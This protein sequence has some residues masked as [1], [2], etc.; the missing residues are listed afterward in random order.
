M[1]EESST[2]EKGEHQHSASVTITITIS[3]RSHCPF[4]QP[5]QLCFCIVKFYVHF[6]NI[7][8]T[9]I[10]LKLRYFAKSPSTGA[11]AYLGG[12]HWAMAPHWVA[13]IL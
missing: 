12:T 11:G 3:K 13:R 10:N 7:I 9:K 8:I 5:V 4:A 2:K 6:K 1:A